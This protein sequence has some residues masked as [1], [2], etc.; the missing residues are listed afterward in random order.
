MPL[1]KKSALI[2]IGRN[3]H[4]LEFSAAGNKFSTSIHNQHRRT[5]FISEVCNGS[6]NSTPIRIPQWIL[7][8]CFSAML[9]ILAGSP[10]T[11]A[12]LPPLQSP[13]GWGQVPQGTGACSVA[14]TCADLAPGMIRHALGPS[15]LE[16]D[17]RTMAQILSSASNEPAA[18]TRAA[19]WAVEAFRRSGADEVHVE[20]F[21]SPAMVE[22]VVA[23]IRGR[24]KP[25]DYVLLVA[26][27]DAA[28]ANSRAT[29]ENAAMLVDAV[30]VI[31]ASG[32]IPHRSIRFLLFG[33]AMPAPNESLAGVWAYLRKHSGDLDRIATVITIDSAHGSLDGY[34]L[35]DRPDTLSAVQQALEPLRSLGI[36][37]FTEG[38]NI[39]SDT[40]PFWLDGVP[41]LVATS[42][43][44]TTGGPDKGMTGNSIR[45]PISP[46]ELK[47]LK[48]GV[49]VTAVS[50]YGIAD[51]ETRI[52]LRRSR[53]DVE[54][55]IRRLNLETKLKITGLWTGWQAAQSAASH[56]A[57]DAKSR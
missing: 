34:S 55:S 21:S 7:A 19:A 33:T 30:R 41:T 17:A 38:V 50:A 12:Q 28:K 48:R 37:N 8:A 24:D 4:L 43:P 42:S 49:A 13:P 35:E 5:G 31:H 18:G 15:S 47:L 11:H 6:S 16:Q 2:N 57:D 32:S 52:G 46:A 51:V 23:E 56:Q 39:P 3:C 10:V 22:N 9:A 14:K 27:L 29:A 1:S 36:R 26:P 54:G 45:T 20:R 44:A 40:T 25:S 53:S